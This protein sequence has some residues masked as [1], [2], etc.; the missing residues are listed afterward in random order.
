MT[1]KKDICPL[2]DGHLEV[3]ADR[4]YHLR[5]CRKDHYLD[6]IEHAACLDCGASI[7]TD[8]VIAHNKER[9][10]AFTASIVKNI[11]PW[12]IREL[13]EKYMLSQ[14]AACRIFQCG[15]V[16]QFSKW[17]RGEVA[18]TGTAAIALREALENPVFMR[19]LANL[20]GERVDVPEVSFVEKVQV[21]AFQRALTTPVSPSTLVYMN[22]AFK[23]IANETT[24][25]LDQPKWGI[26]VGISSRGGADRYFTGSSTFEVVEDTDDIF[27]TLINAPAN[28][29]LLRQTRRKS[30]KPAVREGRKDAEQ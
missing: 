27:G 13:R 20:A 30:G 12:E 15:S 24:E 25:T 6:G 11:A 19:K 17:E 4:R 14:E 10:R 26:N 28:Q 9:V 21:V 3:R 22:E 2:C 18:P 1:T 23:V 7:N 29:P 16:T 5:Y 8:A